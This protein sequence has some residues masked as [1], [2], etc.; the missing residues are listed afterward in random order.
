MRPKTFGLIG[1]KLDHSF[2]RSY[3]TKKFKELQLDHKYLNFELESISELPNLISTNKPNG[4]NVTVP[5]KEKVLEFLDELD[6]IAQEIGAVNT[7]Q[8][9]SEKLIGHNTDAFGFSQAIKPFLKSNHERALVLGTGGASKAV[10]HVLQHLGVECYSVSRSPVDDQ[11]HYQ[12]V[13]REIISACQLIV[14]ATPVGMYPFHNTQPDIP[15]KNITTQHLLVDLIYNPEQT[16]FMKK[17]EDNGATVLNGLTML[18]QQAEKSWSI[19]ND[20]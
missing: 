6:P 13:N 3:F 7:I 16:A 8:F 1:R 5:Y 19:W 15:Y 17:G 14:N 4:L 11:L 9:T 18:K 2:S 12:E 10:L 20:Q